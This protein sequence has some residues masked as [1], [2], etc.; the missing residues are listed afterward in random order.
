M[1]TELER[2]LT[3]ARKVYIEAIDN[4]DEQTENEYADI[5]SAIA[6]IINSGNPNLSTYQQWYAKNEH[7]IEDLE[8]PSEII[9]DVREFAKY[10]KG[11]NKEV[12]EE[13][14]KYLPFDLHA[15]LKTYGMVGAARLNKIFKLN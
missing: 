13:W 15:K 2:E 11:F 3:E 9:A 12:V 5:I 8:C 14:N 10:P 6:K 7:P 4:G 1:A